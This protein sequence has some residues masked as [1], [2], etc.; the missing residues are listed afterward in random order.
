MGVFHIL[1]GLV[2]R[3]KKASKSRA[4]IL[5]LSRGHIFLTC[6]AKK[7]TINLTVV[8]NFFPK[9]LQLD[10][11]RDNPLKKS[12]EWKGSGDESQ[13]KLYFLILFTQKIYIRN[14]TKNLIIK[15][16][17]PSFQKFF[18]ILPC[19]IQRIGRYWF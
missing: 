4:A 14:Y 3:T 1:Y 8:Q 2:G 9:I 16:I 7:Y 12:N 19:E 15:K 11:F 6:Y 5:S 17:G 13:H 18:V 10:F